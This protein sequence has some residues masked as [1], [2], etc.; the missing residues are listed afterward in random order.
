MGASPESI[1]LRCCLFREGIMGAVESSRL[2][3]HRGR[4]MSDELEEETEEARAESGR[5]APTARQREQM[6]AVAAYYR[7]QKR[8]FDPGHDLEDWLEAEAEINAQLEML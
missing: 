1:S 4:E 2:V 3:L 8:N 6:I 7:A 5:A